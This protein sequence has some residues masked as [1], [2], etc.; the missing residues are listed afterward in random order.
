M[1]TST[2][3]DNNSMNLAPEDRVAE[4]LATELEPEEAEDEQTDI[5]DDTPDEEDVTNGSDESTEDDDEVDESDEIEEE[6]DG[7]STEILA[8]A[9]GVKPEQ[10]SVDENGEVSVSVK[11]D[12]VQS[13][14]KLSGLIE[15]YQTQ[16]HNTQKSQALAEERKAFEQAAQ[17]QLTTYQ[18]KINQSEALAT[19][20]Q[21]ELMSEF[22]NENWDEL[23]EFD[24]AG[25]SAKRLDYGERIQRVNSMVEQLQ[26]ER[27][28]IAAQEQEA[29]NNANMAKVQEEYKKVL[30][31]NPD[32]KT[33]EEFK[34]GMQDLKDFIVDSYSIPEAYF[35]QVAD[36]NVIEILKDARAFREGAKRV[37]E[38]KVKKVPKIQSTK[39]RKAKKKVSKLDKLTRA[40]KSA[41]GAAKRGLQQEAVAELL[42]GG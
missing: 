36:A 35:D 12:G 3:T 14:E 40:A 18:E 22:Q 15:G 39:T 17:E 5:T 32:W 23:K 41:K 10:I 26:Q 16:K 31:L 33:H 7:D 34:A 24:P 11:V 25:Y 9:F 38:R 2:S 27:M 13:T 21:Q 28:Q 37:T 4:L 29:R 8:E 19:V 30:E 6:L 1:D 42:L 20:L